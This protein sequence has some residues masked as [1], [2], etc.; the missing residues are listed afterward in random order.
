MLKFIKQNMDTID[1]RIN[2]NFW[3]RKNTSFGA[4]P[5]AEVL[6]FTMHPFPT[7]GKLISI[8]PEFSNLNEISFRNSY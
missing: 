8:H 1:L 2:A 4:Y 3:L 7:K 6:I 5:C